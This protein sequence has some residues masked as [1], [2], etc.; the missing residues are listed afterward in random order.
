MLD[1]ILQAYTSQSAAMVLHHRSVMIARIDL[2]LD[3][4]G[5][6]LRHSGKPRYSTAQSTPP[7]QYES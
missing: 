1:V 6:K 3:G 7:S 5:G 4:T 2:V